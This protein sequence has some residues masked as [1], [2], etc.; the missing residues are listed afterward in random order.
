MHAID[1][2][3]ADGPMWFVA[4]GVGAVIEG[5]DAVADDFEVIVVGAPEGFLEFVNGGA[6]LVALEFEVG[7]RSGAAGGE[8]ER[9][10]GDG[11]ELH[12]L[13]YRI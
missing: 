1:D 4:D 7:E 8:E 11:G 5:G 10:E 3:P 6:G 9:E 13:N 12:E 2:G